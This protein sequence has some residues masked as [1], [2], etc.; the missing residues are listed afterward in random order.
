MAIGNYV[1]YEGDLG[2]GY[3]VN[4]SD[5]NG[6]FDG[7]ATYINT[8]MVPAINNL[9]GAVA[10]LPAGSVV[11]WVP[12]GA[13]PAGWGLC[14]GQ[15]LNWLTGPLAGNSVTL[16]N[17]I[18]MGVQGSDI[19]SGSSTP[20]S[21]GWGATTSGTTVGSSNHS[22]TYSGTTSTASAVIANCTA[23]AGNVVSEQGHS[24][25]YSGTTANSSAQPPALAFPRIMK[26]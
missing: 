19:P 14:N 18:G 12:T 9:I 20:N 10:G 22:H 13:V 17:Y 5:W 25:T 4:P 1:P 8:I 2:N 26:L 6:M 15:T 11:D 16:P 24:H 21:N 7:I 23:G 3:I